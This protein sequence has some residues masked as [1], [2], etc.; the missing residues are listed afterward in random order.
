MAPFRPPVKGGKAPKPQK[1]NEDGESL[2]YSARTL[3]L[4]AGAFPDWPVLHVDVFRG[5]LL[6]RNTGSVLSCSL[7]GQCFCTA[8][9]SEACEVGNLAL[10]VG[11]PLYARGNSHKY[12]WQKTRTTCPAAAEVA[13]TA[14]LPVL[15]FS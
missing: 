13:Y 8:E 1:H 12:L 6:G 2:E 15:L 4:L 11:C 10:M 3:E 14:C 5:K 7:P 9:S